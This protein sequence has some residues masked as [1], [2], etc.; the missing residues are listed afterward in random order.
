M[1]I[2]DPLS[3]QASLH[4]GCQA[5][6]ASRIR[7]RH[8]DLGRLD[9][10]LSERADQPGARFIVTESV[11]SM[12]GDHCDVTALA[13]YSDRLRAALAAQGVDTSA[14][15]TQIVPAIVGEALA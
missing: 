1:S 6:G 8:N 4:H 15:S 2:F 3:T 14:S 5:A 11:F 12:D 7:F 13:A 9:A 10:L